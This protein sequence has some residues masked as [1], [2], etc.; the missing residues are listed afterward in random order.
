MKLA[1]DPEYKKP[2]FVDKGAPTHKT[3]LRIPDHDSGFEDVT[4]I[5]VL[6]DP[7]EMLPEDSWL[8]PAEVDGR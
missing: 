3:A 7:L 1:L 4:F 8:T 6:E 2:V 5:D